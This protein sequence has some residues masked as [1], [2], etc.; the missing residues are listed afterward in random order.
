MA[1]EAELMQALRRADAAGDTAA[2]QAIARRIQSMR[3]APS[4]PLVSAPR[5]Q[6]NR[7]GDEARR[8]PDPTA[9]M[10]DYQKFAAGMGKALYD[11]GRGLAQHGPRMAMQLNPVTALFADKAPEFYTEADAEESRR[12]DAPLMDTGAGVAGNVVGTLAQFVGPGAIGKTIGSAGLKA[13]ALPTTLLGNVAQGAVLGA[14]QP[15]AKGESQL[16]NAAFGAGSAAAGY[17][18]PGLVRGAK[19]AFIDPLTNGGNDRIIANTLSRFADDPAKLA[20]PARSPVPGVNY[21]L[22]EATLDPGI[23]RL[24]RTLMGSTD[25]SNEIGR[26]FSQNNAARVQALQGIAGDEL[27]V[28][29]A[30]AARKQASQSLLNQAKQAE[31]VN[32]RRT[33]GLIDRVLKGEAGER[34][35]IRTALESVKSRL[36]EPYDDAAR[37]SDARGI[38]V[39]AI[40]GRMSSADHAV[41]TEARRLLGNRS[42]IGAAEVSA[43]LK[44]L[45]PKSKAAIEAVSAARKLLNSEAFKG[46]EDVA[47]LYGVRKYI[48][49]LMS[50]KVAGDNAASSAA[51]RELMLVK[52]SLDN[53]ITKAAPEFRDYLKAYRAGSQPI[54][55]MEVGQELLR[56]SVGGTDAMTGAP[57]LQAGTFQR[58]VRN[59]DQ[60]AQSAT[61]F[62]RAKAG[63]ILSPAQQQ[64][65]ADVADSLSRQQF[66]EKAGKMPGSDTFQNLASQNAMNRLG[67]PSVVS[68]LGPVSRV[69]GVFDTALKVAGVPERLQARL[70]QVIADPSQAQKILTRLPNRDREILQAAIA[71]MGT[72]ALPAGQD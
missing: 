43:S 15:T 70:A 40:G 12:A 31:G 39:E 61:G 16:A 19:S 63:G 45:K 55:Q 13:A 56:R 9:G 28:A 27:S 32:V 62:K 34:P 46:K 48:D 35:T 37:M 38:V 20:T 57:I 68:N 51:R 4:A 1:T 59:L 67:M 24:Q 72:R 50:G 71:S 23:A 25:V 2:A 69:V 3:A 10:S 36:F 26:V 11:T 18:I 14:L 66:A 33:A 22:A 41:L 64:T 53:A 29:A 60:V 47:R 21:T 58:N 52:K 7:V 6:I 17:A 8:A 42:G 65:I 44:A 30:E 49:D 54:N 5:V